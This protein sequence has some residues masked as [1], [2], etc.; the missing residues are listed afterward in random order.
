[1]L[2]STK[3]LEIEHKF[4]IP[5][6]W[7]FTAFLGRLQKLH[8]QDSSEVQVAD[9]YYVTK[10]CPGYIHRH[11]YD[12]E[13]QHLTIKSLTGDPEVRL[14]VNLDLGHH[15]GDQR[16]AVQAFL[17]PMGIL[18]SATLNKL[19][20][21]YY[22]VDC[23]VVYYEASYQDR[24]ITCIEI[25]A[26]NSANIMQG[27]QILRH[28]AEVLQLDVNYRSDKTLFE[29]LLAPDMPQELANHFR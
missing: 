28:Y 12:A 14:E 7:D 15:R 29:L 18:W 25:E 20:R 11:R 19:V 27:K 17:S 9:T 26:K 21:A 22:F 13:L 2:E 24:S 8:F 16:E 3:F 5:A 23:E 6:S 1:M 4:I 10:A